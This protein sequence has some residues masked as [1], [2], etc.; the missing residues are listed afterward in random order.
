MEITT[1]H[2]TKYLNLADV[3]RRPDEHYFAATRHPVKD[4]AAAKTDEEFKDMIPDAVSCI[5]ILDVPGCEPMLLLSYEYRS[6]L[7]RYLLGVPAGLIDEEDKREAESGKDAAIHAAR[8]EIREETG[9]S[10]GAAGYAT[11]VNPLLFSSAGLTDESNA[12]VCAVVHVNNMSKLFSVLSQD[13]AEENEHFDGFEL[14]MKDEAKELLRAGRDKNGNFYPIH[15]WA[16]LM[17]FVSDMWK[18]DIF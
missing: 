5:V 2:E 17:Y 11:I 14:L 13:G 7:G 4:M 15:T 3:Q 10:I 6:P 18:K 1:L 12:L 16:A 8:R 9:L